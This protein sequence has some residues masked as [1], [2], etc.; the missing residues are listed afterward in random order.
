M[1][2][3]GVT[4]NTTLVLFW[5]WD[6]RGKQHWAPWWLELADKKALRGSLLILGLGINYRKCTTDGKMRRRFFFLSQLFYPLNH[7]KHLLLACKL[8]VRGCHIICKSLKLYML[9]KS[10]KSSTGPGQ[11]QPSSPPAAPAALE[12]HYQWRTQTSLHQALCKQRT[13]SLHPQRD[14]SLQAKT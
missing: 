4:R 12:Q 6:H 13:R 2:D 3:P 1:D 5:F 11:S 8:L 7:P 10:L 14:Y 9:G